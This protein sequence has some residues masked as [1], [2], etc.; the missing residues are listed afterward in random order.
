MI[1]RPS[2]DAIRRAAPIALTAVVAAGAGA[3]TT[4]VASPLT[5][6][7][8]RAAGAATKAKLRI[9]R[10]G[11]IWMSAEASHVGGPRWAARDVRIFERITSGRYRIRVVFSSPLGRHVER[12]RVRVARIR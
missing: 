12:Y 9:E 8:S 1:T 6:S 10:R 4:V 2:M 7:E 3:G 5:E 11:E